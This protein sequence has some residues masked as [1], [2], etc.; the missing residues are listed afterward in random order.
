MDITSPEH[1]EAV[2]EV[3]AGAIDRDG[4]LAAVASRHAAR[5]QRTDGHP[6]RQRHLLRGDGAAGLRARSS[7]RGGR[8][9]G[10][11]VLGLRD[12]MSELYPVGWDEGGPED[13]DSRD[14]PVTLAELE[15]AAMKVGCPL[16]GAQTAEP[17]VVIISGRN[18]GPLSH[19]HVA[20]LEAAHRGQPAQHEGGR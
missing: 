11:S 4:L 12:G 16:C 19:P 2:A 1:V 13:E 7:R 6:R 8:V 17:C 5:R 14:W 10:R 18:R 3:I 15:S 9:Q 20:R